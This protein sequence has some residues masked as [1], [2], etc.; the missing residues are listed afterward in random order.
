MSAVMNIIFKYHYVLM[1]T[2]LSHS[3]NH[4]NEGIQ[5]NQDHALMLQINHST[6]Q[7]SILSLQP[8]AR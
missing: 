1:K 7:C 5:G 2:D 4:R 3:T 6:I 8:V